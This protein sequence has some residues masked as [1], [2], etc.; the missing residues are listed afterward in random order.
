MYLFFLLPAKT[1]AGPVEET[2][3][4]QTLA[5]GGEMAKDFVT[6]WLSNW[7]VEIT[8]APVLGLVGDLLSVELLSGKT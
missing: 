4:A 1:D 5:G 3:R 8:L 2:A 7:R 6:S